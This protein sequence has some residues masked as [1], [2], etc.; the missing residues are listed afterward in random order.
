M[1]HY[2]PKVVEKLRSTLVRRRKAGIN[3]QT[4]SRPLDASCTRAKHTHARI[5]Q[6]RGSWYCASE[7][8][9]R[10]LVDVI[11]RYAFKAY[12][13]KTDCS[14]FTQTINHRRRSI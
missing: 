11:I 10:V 6:V 4:L 1:R 9:I 5:D 8:Y 12:D 14:H 3:Q 2:L 7:E 13:E